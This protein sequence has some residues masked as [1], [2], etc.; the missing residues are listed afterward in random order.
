MAMPTTS[1][2]KNPARRHACDSR[3]YDITPAM[4]TKLYIDNISYAVSRKFWVRSVAKRPKN[5]VQQSKRFFKIE[6]ENKYV[7]NNIFVVILSIPLI[8]LTDWR[9]LAW[10]ILHLNL[11]CHIF[12]LMLN[13]DICTQK[14]LRC[15]Q[16]RQFLAESFLA[17]F[18]SHACFYL[19]TCPLNYYME[20]F[21]IT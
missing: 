18:H 4:E 1:I 2:R 15:L 14:W 21:F 16:N 9:N 13:A 12:L 6:T 20:F 10:S 3:Q 11:T 17:A 8:S 7:N 5:F 19:W